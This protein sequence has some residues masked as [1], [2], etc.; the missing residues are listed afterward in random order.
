MRPS[1]VDVNESICPPLTKRCPSDLS[2]WRA[3]PLHRAVAPALVSR[4]VVPAAAA[5]QPNILLIVSDDQ[6]WPDLGCIGTQADP[7]AAPRSPGRAKACG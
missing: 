5:E 1:S 7:D 2:P 4:F 6:G 3:A